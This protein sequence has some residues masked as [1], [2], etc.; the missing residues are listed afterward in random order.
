MPII[1][2]TIILVFIA[3][4]VLLATF[5]VTRNRKY[6]AYIKQLLKYTGWLFLVL[7]VLYLITRVI[8]F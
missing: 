5:V 7:F 4:F 3:S 8:R 2:L 1:R 6:L